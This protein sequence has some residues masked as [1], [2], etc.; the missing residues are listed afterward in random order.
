[1]FISNSLNKNLTIKTKSYSFFTN[2]INAQTNKRIINLNQNQNHIQN[3]SYKNKKNILFNKQT[4]NFS[5]KN[6]NIDIPDHFHY[7]IPKYTKNPENVD[8]PWL[9]GGAPFLELK[10]KISTTNL[11]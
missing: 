6:D 9:I 4:F 5:E 7:N 11:Q 1:M 2:L 3:N 10:V 8:F